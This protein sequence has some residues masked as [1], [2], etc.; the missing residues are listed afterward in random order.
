M[1]VSDVTKSKTKSGVKVM[2]FD[3][4]GIIH[5]DFLSQDLIINQQV[6]KEI[7]QYMLCSV[8]EKRWELWQDKLWLLRYDNAPAYTTLS[9][10]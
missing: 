3:V 8:H 9:S 5:N 1:E 6:Y 2:F 10:S 7:L 4:R